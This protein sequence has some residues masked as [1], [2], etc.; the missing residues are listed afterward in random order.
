M[1][2]SGSGW[3]GPWPGFAG[4]DMFAKPS[5]SRELWAG[6]TRR[7]KESHAKARRRERWRRNVA[8]FYNGEYP[9]LKFR[10][11]VLEDV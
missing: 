7:I 8:A 3:N 5:P 9:V 6:F 1:A 11:T 2:G 10:N 4:S